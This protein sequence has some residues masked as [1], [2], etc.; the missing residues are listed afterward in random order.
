[1]ERREEQKT[2]GKNFLR[3]AGLSFTVTVALIIVC[4][5]V[6]TI[7]AAGLSDRYAETVAYRY[8]SFL[9]P[10]ICLFLAAFV[11]FRRA[12]RSI[13]TVAAPC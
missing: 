8:A 13:K 10:Q 7:V 9:L 2:E 1:M 5:F 12:K 3:E 4:S 11:Y 6:V